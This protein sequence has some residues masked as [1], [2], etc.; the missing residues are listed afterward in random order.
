MR[1]YLAAADD[2]A[3][4]SADDP[5]MTQNLYVPAFGAP[6]LALGAAALFAWAISQSDNNSKPISP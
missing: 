4:G 5:S 3:V 6:A 2:T 1:K